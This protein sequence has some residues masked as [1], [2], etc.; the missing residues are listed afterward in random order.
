VSQLGFEPRDELVAGEGVEFD[1]LAVISGRK[2]FHPDTSPLQ[3]AEFR[4]KVAYG[5]RLPVIGYVRSNQFLEALLA[6]PV[7][8]SRICRPQR[9]FGGLRF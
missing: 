9:A 4:Q 1:G 7:G 8:R 6:V 3:T 2:D 5:V